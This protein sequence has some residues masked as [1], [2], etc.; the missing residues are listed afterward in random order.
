MN[1]SRTLSAI[2][3]AV[4][5][6]GASGA[7]LASPKGGEEAQE[8]ATVL[9]AKTSIAQAIAAAEQK[10]GGRAL[11]IDVDKASGAYVYEIKTLS[12]DKLTEV[13]IDPASG[14]ILKTRSEGLI[15]RLLEREDKADMA[16][17]NSAPTTLAT[18]VTAAEQH[19]GGKAIE[20]SFDGEDGHA[21]YKVEVAKDNAV[22][23]VRVNAQ[24]GAVTDHM[25]SAHD[26]DEED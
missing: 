17:I 22:K 3:A 9:G 12:K 23:K 21:V 11:Q 5:A 26:E 14:Q 7:A 15:G 24:T 1:R 20:A 25:S 2:A 19:V 4:I 10:T 16:R 6:F 18:A 13:L 8:I